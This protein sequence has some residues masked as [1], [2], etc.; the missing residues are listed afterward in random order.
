MGS[1][2]SVSEEDPGSARFRLAMGAKAGEML[3]PPP[4]MG[5]AQS[6]NGLPAGGFDFN[7]MPEEAGLGLRSPRCGENDEK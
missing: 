4:A 1:C 3:A 5:G 2:V 7:S 6:G